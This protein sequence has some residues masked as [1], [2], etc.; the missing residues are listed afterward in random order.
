MQHNWYKFMGESILGVN[1]PIHNK[2]YFITCAKINLFHFCSY[3]WLFFIFYSLYWSLTILDSIHDLQN[4]DFDS[5]FDSR[6]D[7]YDHYCLS[8][9]CLNYLRFL[10]YSDGERPWFLFSSLC[11]TTWSSY[12]FIFLL[13]VFF[14]KSNY[15]FV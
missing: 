7:K 9:P 15:I 5:R 1:H 6:F 10:R 13:I 8:M 12:L 14:T 11:L 3:I 2:N 4:Y